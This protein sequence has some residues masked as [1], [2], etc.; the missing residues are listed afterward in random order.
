MSGYVYTIKGNE[1][2]GAIG[3]F[4]MLNEFY[5]R[6]GY[7]DRLV[8][9]LRD[10]GLPERQVSVFTDGLGWF[11]DDDIN[12]RKSWHENCQQGGHTLALSSLSW[13]VPLIVLQ[14]LVRSG[15]DNLGQAT[16]NEVAIDLDEERDYV[17]LTVVATWLQE[18]MEKLGLPPT[19]G[20]Q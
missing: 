1:M 12:P 2:V 5:G 19:G 7:F 17:T 16:G 11:N 15:F 20:D 3:C 13:T 6:C 10:A 18:R 8:R 9:D 4:K 14:A